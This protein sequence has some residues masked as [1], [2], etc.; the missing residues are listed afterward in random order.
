MAA[1]NGKQPSSKS[2]VSRVEPNN[3][4][5]AH[6]HSR[7]VKLEPKSA[8]LPLMAVPRVTG[9]TTAGRLGRCCR[10]DSGSETNVARGLVDGPAWLGRD[11]V[12]RTGLMEANLM[13]LSLG[14]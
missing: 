7:K 11:Q 10:Q 5:A 1:E 6:S 9:G 3:Q 4:D 2:F 12:I 13:S 14:W 8:I